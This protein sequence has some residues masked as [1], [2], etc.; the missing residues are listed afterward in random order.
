MDLSD[1]HFRKTFTYNLRER[2]EEG[3]SHT[4]YMPS[5][6]GRFDHYKY[7]RLLLGNSEVEDAA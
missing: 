3:E 4:Q 6:R 2:Q 5:K 1:P 7:R